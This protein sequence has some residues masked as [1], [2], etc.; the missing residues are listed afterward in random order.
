MNKTLIVYLTILLCTTSYVSYGNIKG[1]KLFCEVK[2]GFNNEKYP[3]NF[4]KILD[5]Y[6]YSF[7]DEEVHYYY[8]LRNNDKILFKKSGTSKYVTNENYIEWV[9]KWSET[10]FQNRLNRKTLV[11]KSKGNNQP[12]FF[13]CKVFV[14]SKWNNKK[15]ELL[16]FFQKKYDEKR[17]GN[18]L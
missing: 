15:K 10:T 4:G 16:D 7:E 6:A 1:K 2:E 3:F 13:L 8:F 9:E 5:Y 11:L 18:K 14:S 17:R 12:H